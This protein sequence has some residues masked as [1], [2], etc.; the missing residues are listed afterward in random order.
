MERLERFVRFVVLVV[1][2]RF[3]KFVKFVK[4]VKY[5]KF[6]KLE[7]MRLRSRTAKSREVVEVRKE[8]R[9]L[10]IRKEIEEEKSFFRKNIGHCLLLL[11]QSAVVC[12][13][14]DFRA[15]IMRIERNFLTH[16]VDRMY[17]KLFKP[18]FTLFLMSNTKKRFFCRRSNESEEP[19][20]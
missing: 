15:L 2:V 16:F 7:V 11:T 13:K 18:F 12:K 6:V 10:H 3:M 14:D 4:F 19:S 1:F 17:M 9:N 20:V 8:G 5:V